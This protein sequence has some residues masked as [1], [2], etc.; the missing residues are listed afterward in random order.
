MMNEAMWEN[1][2]TQSNLRRL[3]EAGYHLVRRAKAR[4]RV[5]ATGRTVRT[6]CCTEEMVL[7]VCEQIARRHD[8]ADATAREALAHG[9]DG[10]P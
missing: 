1:S 9:G 3:E 4:V 8:T 5:R 10:S 7:S 6:L 2:L